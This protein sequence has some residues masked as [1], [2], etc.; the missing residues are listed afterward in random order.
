MISLKNITVLLGAIASFALAAPV[1]QDNGPV[2]DV[3][4]RYIITLKSDISQDKVE[5]HLNWVEDVH[6]RSL[7]RRD[8][9]GVEKVY[10]IEDF[11]AYSGTFDS[12]TIEE[13]KKSPD[14]VDIEPDQIYTLDAFVTQSGAPWGLGTV[15]S[16]TSGSTTYRYDDSAGRSTY[17]YV[18]DS[19]IRITHNDFGGRA[20]RGYNAAGG[21]FDDT[22]G[23]GT[24]VAGTIGGSTYGVAKSTNL[25]DVKVFIGR[26]STTAIILDGFNWAVN[27]ITSKGR[28][29]RAVINLS[30]GGPSSTT[31]TN[32][33]NAAFNAGILSVAASGNENQPAANRSP[34]NAPNALTVGAINSA[35][36][37]DTYSNY[38][39]AVDILAPGTGVLSLGISS[40]SATVSNTGTSM[41]TPHVVGVALYL[42]QLEGIS[43][44]SALKARILAL[45]T[46]GRVN[47]LRAGSPNRVLY[48]GNA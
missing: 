36:T 6:K 29:G 42:A 40:N 20:V 17:A 26:Q 46:T 4:D 28:A 7:N 1:A 9:S 5:S 44:P 45:G 25:V 10:N 35:W 2:P 14:V 8:L 37:E 24:H 32:A 31:W 13:L 48:N 39:S 41:A 16:R 30:L 21:T 34:A 38:G 33:I 3:A 15:S 47:G 27:D 19:G 12:D 43:S 11:H 22:F 23:H 18:V